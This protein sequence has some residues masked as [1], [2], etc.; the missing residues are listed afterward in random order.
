MPRVIIAVTLLLKLSKE[1]EAVRYGHINNIAAVRLG[2]K[3]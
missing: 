3:V 1:W 2:L